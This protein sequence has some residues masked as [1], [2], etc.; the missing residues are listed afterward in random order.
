MYEPEPGPLSAEDSVAVVSALAQAIWETDGRGNVN[1][2]SPSWRAYTGQTPDQWLQSGWLAAVHPAEQRDAA[3][4]WEEALATGQPLNAGFRV[5]QAGG[6]WKLTSVRMIPVSGEKDTIE[7]WI[8]CL[9][10]I[11]D[12]KIS[13]AAAKQESEDRFDMLV[14]N[15]PTRER[16]SVEALRESEE[17]LRILVES[18]VDHAI[19][20]HDPDGIITSWNSGAQH[21]FGYTETE[22]VGQPDALIFT[23]QDRI[24]GE[25]EEERA[26][27]WREG[28]ALDERYH[29]R[30]DGSLVYLSGVMAPLYN[31]DNKLIG[32]VKVARDLTQ[33][34]QM[35]LAL[36]EADRR[37]D[38]FM[39]MLGHELRNPLAPIRNVIHILK[40]THGHDQSLTSSLEMLSRQV[41]HM[42]RLVNDLLDM[43]RIVKGKIALRPEPIDLVAVT[44]R[45][46][47]MSRP[48]FD[49]A[50]RV[51]TVDLPDHAIFINGDITRIMQIINNLLNNGAKFTLPAGHVHV[52]VAQWGDQVMM[53]IQD[54]GLGISGEHLEDIFETFYQIDVAIDRSQGGLGLGLSMVKQL[55]ELHGGDVQVSSPGLGLGT[56]FTVTFP[57]IV[58]DR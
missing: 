42:V 49:S 47:E 39:A 46:I 21:I 34:K 5:Q 51:L 7:K 54:D 20:T 29:K 18:I 8:G 45:A 33:R 10:A 53:Q 32:F 38:E 23:E 43:T 14:Q 58:P 16:R 30:K 44:T 40:M 13:G 3:A 1:A 57:A 52:R 28:R 36:R 55:V 2:D 6:G 22:A 50:N 26:T 24:D 31:P 27:A 41:D 12:H 35:E 11:P 4:V 56:T 48:M 19:I 17:R 37:K 9:V 15:L 25:H